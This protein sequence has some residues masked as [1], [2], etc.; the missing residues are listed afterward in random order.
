MRLDYHEIMT[1]LTEAYDGKYTLEVRPQGPPPPPVLTLR[2]RRGFPKVIVPE[3]EAFEMYLVLK[4]YF[5]G[6]N[7]TE[8][9]L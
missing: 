8:A 9:K 7:A 1:D 4:D 3:D 5:E 6:T 2:N